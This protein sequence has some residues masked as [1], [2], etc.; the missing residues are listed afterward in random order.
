MKYR[1]FLIYASILALS[2]NFVILISVALNQGWVRTRAAGGQYETFPITIRVIYF[3]M[4]IFM[5]TLIFWLW[6]HRNRSLNPQSKRLT[7]ILG[8]TFIVS[9]FLQL[10]SQS[11]D[12]RWNAIPAIVLAVTFLMM[13]IKR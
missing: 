4:A 8:Y 5:A 7:R 10:I 13:G 3:L 11:P 12:E 9:T 1:T 6:D 2:Y